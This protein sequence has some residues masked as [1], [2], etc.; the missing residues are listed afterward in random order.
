MKQTQV[1]MLL[2][3]YYFS[4]MDTILDL[5]LHKIHARNIQLEVKAKLAP[6]LSHLLHCKLSPLFHLWKMSLLTHHKI[7]KQIVKTQTLLLQKPNLTLL[8][9]KYIG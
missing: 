3:F 8:L 5:K 6:F 4:E 7:N 1:D 2:V 9:L